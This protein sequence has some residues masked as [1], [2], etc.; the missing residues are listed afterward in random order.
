MDW[1]FL[2]LQE[3]GRFLAGGRIWAAALGRVRGLAGGERDRAGREV[4]EASARRI[5]HERFIRGHDRE[6]SEF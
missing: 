5:R 2:V 4:R 6:M 3:E 1:S